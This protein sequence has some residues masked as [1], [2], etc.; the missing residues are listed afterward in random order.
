MK[1]GEP[2]KQTK[3]VKA[4]KPA[5]LDVGEMLSHVGQEEQNVPGEQS[6][7]NLRVC[8]EYLC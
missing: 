4:V 1:K 7:G 6:P 3:K 8:C 5:W 2:P